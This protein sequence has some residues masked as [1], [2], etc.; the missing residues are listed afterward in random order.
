MRRLFL[1]FSV[2]CCVAL[3]SCESGGHFTVLGYTTK[4]N[5]DT[6][7]KTVYVPIFE[8]KTFYR[9]LEFDLTRAVIKE[10][11]WKTPFK[12]VS[13]R[14]KADT[15]LTG[16]IVAYNKNILNRNQL[17]EVR[18]AEMVLTVGVVWKDLRSG[19]IISQPRAPGVN[20]PA[21]GPLP[22]LAPGA[23]GVPTAPLDAGGPPCPPT[24]PAVVASTATYAPEIGQSN[25]SAR[26][27]NVN[28]LATQIVSLMEKPW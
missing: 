11:E 27:L 2:I 26:Q 16:T 3:A 23:S 6:C 28:R 17:N 21:F 7:I 18:E 13:D 22:D 8:N 4:P 14:S 15:E 20:S 24:Q 12:V 9:G 19:E 25:A 5:Y 1:S 10:I